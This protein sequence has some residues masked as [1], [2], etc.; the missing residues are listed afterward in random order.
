MAEF[1]RVTR[2]YQITIPKE[3]REKA[4]IKQ[5]MLISF[6]LRED[7]ILMRPM[8]LVPASQEWFWT[9]EWQKGEREADEDIREGRISEPM[10]LDEM[11][12][13]FEKDQMDEKL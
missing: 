1:S 2:S 7:G 3:I 10:S 12:E 11:R 9:E 6:E 8:K 5:G 4:G 13:Y